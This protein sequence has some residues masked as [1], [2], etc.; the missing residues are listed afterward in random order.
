MAAGEERGYD[1]FISYSHRLDAAITAR[2]QAELQRFAKPWYRMRALHV[3][4]DQTSLAASP[5]L[6]TTIE[7]ALAE[8]S[9]LILMASPES[10]QSG[11]V[12]REISWWRAHRPVNNL[13]IAVTDGALVWDETARDL[14]WAA[15]TA[16]SKEALGHGFSEEPRWV[17]LRWA[18]DTEAS[19]RS[20]DPRLQDAVADLAAAIRHVPKDSL[21]GEHIQHQRRAVRAVIAVAAVLVVLL[22]FSLTA[23]FIAKGQ[24]DRAD[25]ENTVATAGLLASTA[26]ALT[27]SRPD[28][29]QLFA[30]Q[31]YRL[32][33]GNPQ[34]RAALFATV[35]ADPQVQRFLMAPGPVSAL[36]ISPDGRVIVAGTRNGWVRGWNLASF[37][38][39]S[40]G[41]LA[42]PVTGV[43]VSADGTTVAAATGR[44]ARTWVH[45]RLVASRSAP[46]G[47]PFTA[48]GVSPTGKFA[49]F[50]AYPDLDVLSTPG[51]SWR[52]A[53]LAGFGTWHRGRP[54]L[55]TSL[56]VPS[57]TELVALD[58]R[59]GSWRR[60]ALPGL[61]TAG[62]ARN[63]FGP[64]RYPAYTYALSPAG[65]LFTHSYVAAG[66]SLHVL[67]TRRSGR[68]A[69]RLAGRARPGGRLALALAISRNGRW[70]ASEDATGIH[71]SRIARPA[72]PA[73][74]PRS[75]PG[76]EPLFSTALAFVG[77][78]DSRLISASGNLLT[79]WN[80]RQFSRIG[81]AARIPM[82]WRC[83]RVCPGPRLAVGPGGGEAALTDSNGDRLVRA[84]LG[85]SFGKITTLAKGGTE[86]FG[87][88]LWT[89]TGNRLY[90][91]G[92]TLSLITAGKG[93]VAML[94][95]DPDPPQALALSADG[96][97]LFTVDAAGTVRT[98]A[99]PSGAAAAGPADTGSVVRGSAVRGPRG[100]RPN[101]ALYQRQA[102][103]SPSGTRA[104]VIDQSNQEVY[105]INLT[106]RRTWRIPGVKAYEL[107][108]SGSHL[109]LQREN[110]D[111]DLRDA[112]GTRVIR[113]V[114]TGTPWNYGNIAVGPGPAAGQVLVAG[115]RADGRGIVTDLGSGH[116]LG[117]F[118][119]GK[120]SPYQQT[121]MA[122]TPGGR[123]LVTVTEGNGHTDDGVLT[124]LR[125]TPAQ[126]VRVA[127]TTSGH[128]LTPGDWRHYIS[129]SP[130]ARLG[131]AP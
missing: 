112:D 84:G 22:A 81:R 23:A 19:L 8:S 44:S 33:P 119:I 50:A 63:T 45:G 11:W 40:Y 39:V 118:P 101:L 47:T 65:T 61:T 70:V 13:L 89:R 73:R 115:E 32:D 125:M 51:R 18:R 79:L 88:P 43:A 1:A 66:S 100:I 121:T 69:R 98:G 80:L 37:T 114:Q 58:G 120:A 103:V 20:A 29:A 55:V 56:A 124:Q 57:D 41:R 74:P 6:W 59:Y 64:S 30:V 46:A 48:V 116:V 26:V 12:S 72:G 17:D 102:A 54:P 96:N 105:V 107:A 62:A 99:V 104:A 94:R 75:Y 60:L 2:L 123:S 31:A 42:G 14:D 130:P 28:L 77:G 131:C 25:R 24:R 92:R 5:H 71:V 109:V 126:W 68:A 49:A 93:E 34:A 78:S 15:T 36:A 90:V 52:Q 4:R 38:P 83:G 76:A 27:G 16:L 117:V 86:Q 67:S 7:E 3:F 108:Y 95:K 35:Q 82:P 111:I 85:P 106:T 9:W 122:L 97:R 87:L 53:R 129:P 113:S 127:C 110:G 128:G 91:F 21:I 10:A